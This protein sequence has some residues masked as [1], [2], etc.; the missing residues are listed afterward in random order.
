MPSTVTDASLTTARRR[1]LALFAWRNADKLSQSI[2]TEQVGSRGYRSTGP[3]EDIPLQAYLGAQL[4]GQKVQPS[5]GEC[6]CSSAVTLQGFV[7]QS[8]GC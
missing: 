5:G 4:V 7:R 8:P 3:S 2:R 1:Q 6:G